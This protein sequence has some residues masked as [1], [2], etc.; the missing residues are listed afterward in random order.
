[1]LLTPVS[2]LN[3]YDAYQTGAELK[4][5]TPALVNAYGINLTATLKQAVLGQKTN[6]AFIDACWHQ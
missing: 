6:G 1:V 2:V 3:R 4:S 5:S